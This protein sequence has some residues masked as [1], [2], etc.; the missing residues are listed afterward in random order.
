ML[1]V[2]T[3]P[4]VAYLNRNDTDHERCASLLMSR[5]DEL[6][7]TPYVL[8]EAC[9]L[10]AKYV[11]ADAE[12][13]LVDATAVGDLTQ[14]DVETGDLDRMVEIMRRYRGFPLG[15]ADASVIAVAERLKITEIATLDHRHF[16]AV[17][18]AHVSALDLLP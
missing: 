5:V 2:D 13:N 14:V 1:L 3:G 9:Y 6:L 11:G 18:P 10:V 15:L 7:V 4:L 8:T 16:H 12:I 17:T